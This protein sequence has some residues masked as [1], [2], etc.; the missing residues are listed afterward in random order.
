MGGGK[1]GE[2]VEQDIPV[3]RDLGGHVFGREP[4]A[5]NIVCRAYI[6][7]GRPAV[8]DDDML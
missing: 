6:P 4:E 3:E 7:R 2:I 8:L 5:C 1:G